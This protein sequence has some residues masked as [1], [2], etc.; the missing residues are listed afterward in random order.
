MKAGARAH[1]EEKHGGTEAGESKENA[2]D[3]HFPAGRRQEKA[4][5]RRSDHG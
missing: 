1:D 4:A 2:A 3:R 5:G